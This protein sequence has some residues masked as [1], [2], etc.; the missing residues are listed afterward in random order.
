M[1]NFDFLLPNRHIFG[2][3]GLYDIHSMERLEFPVHSCQSSSP[4]QTNQTILTMKFIYRDIHLQGYKY[5][6]RPNN[7]ESEIYRSQHKHTVA[8]PMAEMKR[9]DRWCCVPEG[10]SSRKSLK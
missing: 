3:V 5:I 8:C 9:Y 1:Q 6:S 7:S 10:Q 4:Q 2:Q